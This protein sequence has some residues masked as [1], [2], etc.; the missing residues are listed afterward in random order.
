MEHWTISNDTLNEQ[1]LQHRWPRSRPVLSGRH[2]RLNYSQYA[3]NYDRIKDEFPEQFQKISDKYSE[4]TIRQQKFKWNLKTRKWI[5]KEKE[6]YQSNLNPRTNKWSRCLTDSN[7]Q[8]INIIHW[9]KSRINK[10]VMSD[11]IEFKNEAEVRI[12]SQNEE[13][14]E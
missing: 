12:L 7:H 13:E 14:V 10:Q 8:M 2:N 9:N 11:V 1:T 5:F 3:K 4:Q 6:G